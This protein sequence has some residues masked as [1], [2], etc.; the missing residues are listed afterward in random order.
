MPP[1]RELAGTTG[2]LVSYRPVVA[3]LAAPQIGRSPFRGSPIVSSS[4]TR[5][6]PPDTAE[7]AGSAGSF[8]AVRQLTGT[9]GAYMDNQSVAGTP[10]EPGGIVISLPAAAGRHDGGHPLRRA[11]RRGGTPPPGTPAAYPAAGRMRS[12]G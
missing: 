3:G 4:S 10:G 5:E 6:A 12:G 2:T 8:T 7:V 11:P 1:P 9:I